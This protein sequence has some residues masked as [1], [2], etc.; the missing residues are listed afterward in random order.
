MEKE[1]AKQIGRRIAKAIAGFT[2]GALDYP[3]AIH[4]KALSAEEQ[5]QYVEAWSQQAD[6]VLGYELPEDEEELAELLGDLG[7]KKGWTKTLDA[8][9]QQWYESVVD[10]NEAP[11]IGP[12]NSALTGCGC[13][14][15][16]ERRLCDWCAGTGRLTY[17]VK[18]VK[19]N[20]ERGDVLLPIPPIGGAGK[21]EEVPRAPLSVHE[22]FIQRMRGMGA[23]RVDVTS[24]GGLR[25][26]F[27]IERDGTLTRTCVN[28]GGQ[29]SRMDDEN[30]NLVGFTCECGAQWKPKIGSVVSVSA[31]Q[32]TCPTCQVLMQRRGDAWRCNGCGRLEKVKR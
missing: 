18:L 17:H 15:G 23:V 14:S 26:D 5:R 27:V 1:Q 2:A 9:M 3:L 25:V 10:P 16:E 24:R 31:T 21:G 28:C 4:W 19:E 22:A 13:A 20:A 32:P 30:G 6:G 11:T 7:R 29:M 8:L 12:P